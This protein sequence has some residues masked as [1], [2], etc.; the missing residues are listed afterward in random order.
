[1]NIRFSSEMKVTEENGVAVLL[2]IFPQHVMKTVQFLAVYCHSQSSTYLTLHQLSN[3]RASQT[4]LL[5]CRDYPSRDEIIMTCPEI[6]F[7]P[8][9]STFLR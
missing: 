9:F 2:I 8:L 3:F 4:L 6:L 7:V 5:L 1:M